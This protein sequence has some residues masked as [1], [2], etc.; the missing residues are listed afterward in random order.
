MFDAESHPQADHGYRPRRY[1]FITGRGRSGSNRLTDALDCH[2]N[3]FCRSEPSGP[4]ESYFR[5]LPQGFIAN[6]LGR[7]FLADWRRAIALTTSE[8]SDRDRVFA[9]FKT[10]KRSWLHAEFASRVFPKKKLRQALGL[11][12]P[13]M[14]GEVWP[15]SYIYD[16]EKIR[17]EATLV[18]KVLT[19]P[20]WILNA[21]PHEE[22]MRLVLNI[23]SPKPFIQSWLYRYVGRRDPERVFRESAETLDDVLAH[24]GQP[25]LASTAYSEEALIRA[26]LWRWRY[27]NEQIFDACKNSDRFTYVTYEAFDADPIAECER[28]YAFAG[29]DMDAA[30][31]RRIETLE[32]KIFA[33]RPK[34]TENDAL[35]DRLVEEIAA[36]SP[37]MSLL[38]SGA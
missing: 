24:Y 25:P 2:E 6:D 4:R 34:R 9:T 23:R 29:L 38:D 1:V 3:A 15:S 16:E 36:P 32:N 35:I 20:G 27:A 12:L 17:S 11:V 28:L 8:L 22:N 30:A 5:R 7:D 33:P 19:R 18:I 31:R 13:K 26:E 21:F 37:L 10:F 14:A